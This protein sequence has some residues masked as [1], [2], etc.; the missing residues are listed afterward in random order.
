ML[1]RNQTGKEN[2][3]TPFMSTADIAEYLGVSWHTAKRRIVDRIHEEYEID[4]RRLPRSGVL[5]T[6]VVME[7]LSKAVVKKK[8]R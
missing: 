4:E 6:E 3:N 7:Y 2:K 1:I 5:P 8:K